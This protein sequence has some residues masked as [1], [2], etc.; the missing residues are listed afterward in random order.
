[1]D[2]AILRLSRRDQALARK[3]KQRQTFLLKVVAFVDILMGKIG[4]VT[5]NEQHSCHTR[6]TREVQDFAG[7]VI[8]ED[9]GFSMM[10]G[11][12]ISLSFGGVSVFTVY[13]QS[14]TPSADEFRVEFWNKEKP[15]YNK[16][17]RVMKDKDKIICRMEKVSKNKDDERRREVV[18]GRLSG[19]S[20]DLQSEAK[21]LGL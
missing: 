14:C 17:L 9:T 11:N 10:G 2:M 21:R 12:R 18:V 1:M 20:S 6:V 5:R 16:F 8:V 4:K 19:N 15:W 3:I 7:F 13:W